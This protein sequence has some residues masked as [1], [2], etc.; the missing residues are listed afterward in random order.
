MAKSKS[1][2]E[3]A[4]EYYRNNY[5]RDISIYNGKIDL[6][7]D[8]IDRLSIVYEKLPDLI[9]RWH[10]VREDVISIHNEVEGNWRGQIKDKYMEYSTDQLF[11]I[12]MLDY[13]TMMENIEQDIYDKIE[14]LKGIRSSWEQYVQSLKS[15][16]FNYVWE[17][18]YGF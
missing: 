17:E 13:K 11:M 12:N 16:Y 10:W 15:Q 1:K 6:Y 4:E 5:A 3:K 14:E 9:E 2:S 8:Y 7:S 18:I